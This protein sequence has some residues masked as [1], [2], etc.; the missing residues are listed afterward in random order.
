MGK[1][2]SRWSSVL[3]VRR[4]PSSHKKFIL[5]LLIAP[6]VS[7]IIIIFIITNYNARSADIKVACITTSA[8]GIKERY[9]LLVRR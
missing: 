9:L 8:K 2:L 4:L 5:S 3:W 7:I 6:I 1:A